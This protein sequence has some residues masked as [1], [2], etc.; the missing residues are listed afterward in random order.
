MLIPVLLVL[1][2]LYGLYI[3]KRKSIIE[4]FER[5]KE[6]QRESQA[7]IER[8]IKTWMKLYYCDRDQ[9]VF[10]PGQDELVPPDQMMNFLLKA[11]LK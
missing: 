4:K 5:Q 8:G 2:G 1:A 3:F 11:S 6:G 9:G 7:R 10:L